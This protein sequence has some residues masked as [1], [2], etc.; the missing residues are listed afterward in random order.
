MGK[1][2]HKTGKYNNYGNSNTSS[3]EDNCFFEMPFNCFEKQ[4]V[5]KQKYSSN[6]PNTLNK[7]EIEKYVC[8]HENLLFDKYNDEI[9][10]I[11]NAAKY[12]SVIYDYYD[13]ANLSPEVFAKARVTF[14]TMQLHTLDDYYL[15]FASANLLNTSAK[16]MNSGYEFK[17]RL[18]Q[19]IKAISEDY[20]NSNLKNNISFYS[21]DDRGLDC[22]FVTIKGVQFSYH[23][24]FG[25]N[26]NNY[27]GAQKQDWSGKELQ[28]IA[29]DV[30]EYAN[31]LSDLSEMSCVRDDNYDPIPLKQL[32][33]LAAENC[34]IKTS[35]YCEK[36]KDN[37][38]IFDIPTCES[39]ETK[40]LLELNDKISNDPKLKGLLYNQDYITAYE[41]KDIEALQTLISK[42]YYTDTNVVLDNEYNMNIDKDDIENNLTN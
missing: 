7:N 37:E 11:K 40:Y 33:T 18:M 12:N 21:K 23:V 28:D 42:Y 38:N 29:V 41:N 31:R 19:G 17:T 9:T 5:S 36:F 1:Q 4:N 27:D 6:Q 16:T 39:D 30:W 14:E 26:V 20:K 35:P 22:L 8:L 2:K 10:Y 25:I 34:H 24:K 13:M 15:F 32:Q 3:F